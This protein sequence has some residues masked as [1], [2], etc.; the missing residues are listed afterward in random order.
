MSALRLAAAL[1]L[2]SAAGAG[3]LPA[4]SATGAAVTARGWAIRNVTII[5]VTGPRI[6]R[7]TVVIRNGKIEAAGTNA[8]PQTGDS[9]LDGTGLFVYPGM[10]DAGSRLG[11]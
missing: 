5:P 8:A 11:L 7:G 1:A 9:V 6:E 2:I 3:Q 4:Q 10:I